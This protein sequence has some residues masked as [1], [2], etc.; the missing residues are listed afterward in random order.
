MSTNPP[1]QQDQLL[2]NA[3]DTN[4]Q[5]NSETIKI[6]T[7]L[8]IPQITNNPQENTFFNGTEF[9]DK[10]DI[11]SLILPAGWSGSTFP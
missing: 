5:V 10:N 11:E 9:H 8:I 1:Q 6:V 2:S 4:Q 7:Q 3:D